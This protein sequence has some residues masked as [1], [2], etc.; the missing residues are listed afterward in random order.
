MVASAEARQRSAKIRYG[1]FPISMEANL[2]CRGRS[3]VRT[4][5][6]HRLRAAVVAVRL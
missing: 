4:G 5:A 6:L 1:R 3:G 2:R